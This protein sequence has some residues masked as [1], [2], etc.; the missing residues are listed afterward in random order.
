MYVFFSNLVFL[1]FK[2][3]KNKKSW[4]I[5]FIIL[6][7]F[8]TQFG[9][10]GKNG[11]ERPQKRKKHVGESSRTLNIQEHEKIEKQILDLKNKLDN[12]E[13]NLK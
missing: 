7:L 4:F 13:G 6:T 12:W 11:N 10:A 9:N 3:M 8:L 1:F 5:L 2:L